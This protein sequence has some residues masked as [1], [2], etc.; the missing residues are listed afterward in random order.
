MILDRILSY[1]KIELA[2]RRLRRC[3]LCRCT[4]HGVKSGCDSSENGF[5]ERKWRP[6]TRLSFFSFGSKSFCC[7]AAIHALACVDLLG[8]RN[9]GPGS[10]LEQHDE[11]SQSSRTTVTFSWR[12]CSLETAQAKKKEKN[13]SLYGLT[14]PQ[15]PLHWTWSGTKQ[16]WGSSEEQ[17]SLHTTPHMNFHCKWTQRSFAQIF[18]PTMADIK[19]RTSES[20]ARG[21]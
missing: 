21:L 5:H 1:R 6:Q 20:S 18:L 12:N 11:C 14:M 19:F 8:R 2:P 10:I 16:E 13:L 15:Q 7:T 3:C 17:K 9:A 4:T